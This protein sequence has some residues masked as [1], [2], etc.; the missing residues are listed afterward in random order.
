MASNLS[1]L[2]NKK[3]PEENILILGPEFSGRSSAIKLI[4]N[5]NNLLKTKA[6][7]IMTEDNASISKPIEYGSLMLESGDNIH[8]IRIDNVFQMNSLRR[9]WENKFLGFIL[10]VDLNAISPLDDMQKMLQ[11]FAPYLGKTSLSVGVINTNKFTPENLNSVNQ[12]LKE[13]GYKVA[14]FDVDTN[15]Y[16]DVSLLIQ[17]MLVS[18]LQGIT[19]ALG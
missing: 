6:V 7:T 5:N 9:Y 15:N 12:R 17:S 2:T 16:S 4:C 13:L 10:M 11:D 8:L 14:A 1:Y 19:Y 18:N 3:M